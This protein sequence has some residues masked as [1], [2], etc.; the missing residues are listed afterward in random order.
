MSGMWYELDAAQAELKFNTS[1]TA[2]LSRKAAS[3]LLAENR[4]PAGGGIFPPKAVSAAKAVFADP[5]LLAFFAFC[6]LSA[7]IGGGGLYVLVVAI[8]YALVLSAVNLLISLAMART[9]KALTPW[10]KVRRDGKLYY[11]RADGVVP[12]DLLYLTAGDYIPADALV[13]ASQVL[14]VRFD[15]GE[16]SIIMSKTDQNL[17]P[18]ASLEKL[19]LYR[20]SNILVAG[21]YVTGGSGLA[22]AAVCGKDTYAVQSALPAQK[23]PEKP[24][25]SKPAALEGVSLMLGISSLGF[26]FVYTLLS[27]IP[28]SGAGVFDSFFAAASV[29]ALCS[30]GLIRAGARVAALSTFIIEECSFTKGILLN[31]PEAAEKFAGIKTLIINDGAFVSDG[32]LRSMGY[33]TPDTEYKDAS[34]I[35]VE[36]LRNISMVV[37]GEPADPE[38]GFP[39]GA[40]YAAT[41]REL[42]GQAGR[43]EE[44]VLRGCRLVGYVRRGAA[45]RFDTAVYTYEGKTY[46]VCRDFGDSLIRACSYAAKDGRLL[47]MTPDLCGELLSARQKYTATGVVVMTTATA[48]G[49]NLVFEGMTLLSG[50][51]QPPAESHMAFARTGIRVIY[52]SSEVDGDISWYNNTATRGDNVINCD[53]NTN[54]ADIIAN[55]DI[56][57]LNNISPEFLA[58]LVRAAGE[59]G[60][61]ALANCDPAFSGAAAYATL[62]ICCIPFDTGAKTGRNACLP[63]YNLQ[64]AKRRS[65]RLLSDSDIV[66]SQPRNIS[67]GLEPIYRC[68]KYLSGKAQDA[69]VYREYLVSVFALRMMLMLVFGISGVFVS[70]PLVTAACVLT[71]LLALLVLSVPDLWSRG[72]ARA[73]DTDFTSRCAMPRL[74]LTAAAAILMFLLSRLAAGSAGA[75]RAFLFAALVSSGIS[76]L[77]YSAARRITPSADSDR[78]IA[79]VIG[80]VIVLSVMTVLTA[81]RPLAALLDMT[82]TARGIISATTL[83][84]P[85]VLGALHLARKPLRRRAGKNRK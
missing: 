46:R 8:F 49:N 52:T 84:P 13:T 42:T 54:A 58:A 2:G 35:P 56:T 28:W 43:R 73:A 38:T 74:A 37:W 9:Q 10:C 63:L 41:L 23:K 33:T 53:R 22:I 48:V 72:G 32:R 82:P 34:K 40:E 85:V 70:A 7:L 27:L 30:S 57:Y 44:E 71:D 67:G 81:V 59:R 24:K 45:T 36:H 15:V 3:A 6:L 39:R 66:L 51:T 16:E 80:G 19:P 20:R 69:A 11:V 14:R 47:P 83:A 62:N 79:A 26:V 21:S 31:N 29:A 61:V 25:A 68:F 75:D 64:D 77:L 50:N 4:Q 65:A 12:G 55:H 17:S 76:V 5:V 60:G 1:M 78:L 18:A